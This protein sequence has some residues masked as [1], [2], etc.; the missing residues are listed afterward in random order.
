MMH[1]ALANRS[2]IVYTDFTSEQRELAMERIVKFVRASP[3]DDV[4]AALPVESVHQVGEYFKI[5][6][7]LVLRAE[8][9]ASENSRVID[10][11]RRGQSRRGSSKVNDDPLQPTGTSARDVNVVD[12]GSDDDATGSAVGEE[13]EDGSGFAVGVAPSSSRPSTVDWKVST[14]VGESDEYAINGSMSPAAASKT[15]GSP[16]PG[17]SPTAAV[18]SRIFHTKSEAYEVFKREPEGRSLVDEL[19]VAKKTMRE[20]RSALITAR[21]VLN[22]SKDKIASLSN[23]LAEKK[24]TRERST[25]VADIPNAGLS[26]G[27][28][29]VDEEEYR[30]IV[31]V[32]NEK[33][34]YR[35]LMKDYTSAKAGFDETANNLVAAKRYLLS[36]FEE[37]FAAE[38]A[39]S[40]NAPGEEEE[41]FLDPGEAFQQ[42]EQDRI[43]SNEPGSLPFFN[44]NKSMRKTAGKSS[45]RL[46]RTIR[47][48]RLTK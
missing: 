18:G 10:T 3:S 24:A 41:L 14:K 22:G 15:S 34:R 39:K 42:L 20:S 4:D 45:A 9:E 16:I 48:K 44:A 43:Q 11:A 32:R 12:G 19:D 28:V 31:D 26:E 1:D 2:G 5:F 17:T 23:V 25:S 21:D 36:S 27:D 29:I 35:T 6:K 46:R 13:E 47:S 30:F 38:T 8:M 33:K 37:W 40:T 7:Q